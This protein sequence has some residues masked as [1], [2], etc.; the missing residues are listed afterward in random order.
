MPLLPAYLRC[1]YLTDPLGLEVAQPRLSWELAAGRRG[2]GQ[3][4]Y[5][6]RAAATRERLQADQPDLWDT[7]R[8]A[9]PLTTQAVYAGR[10]LAARERAWWQVRVWD[11]AEAPGPWSAPAWWEMGLLT[12]AAWQAQ[13]I[14]APL[15]GGPQTG[16]PAPFLRRAFTLARPPRTAR[17]YVTALGLYEMRLN[18]Q[19]V[20]E[21]V[22]TPGWT[23]YRRRVNYQAYDVTALLNAGDN[24]LGAVLG[25]G[26]YCG[27]LGWHG[28]QFYGDRP[29]LLAQLELT[30]D[31]GRTTLVSD[32]SWRY[33]FGPLLANDLLMGESYDAR[34]EQPGWDQP[35]FAEAGWAPAAVFPDPGL[36]LSGAPGPAVRPMGERTPIAVRPVPG[37]EPTRWLFDF[38]QNL[39]GRTRLTVSG[40]RGLTLTLRFAEALTA[41][42]QLY[43]ANLRGARQ[44][45]HYTLRGEGVETYEPRFTFHGFRYVEVAG[46]PTPLT[47]EALTAIVLHSET[48]PTGEFECSDPLLNQLQQ[49]IQWGQRGNF[50]EV[51]TDCPQRDERLGWTGDAQV[52]VRTAAFNMDVAAFFTK[53]Q[54]DLAEAQTALGQIPPVAP[55]VAIGEDGGPAWADAVLICPWTIYQCYGDER[56][57]AEHYPVFVRYLDYLR[58]TSPGLI[59]AHPEGPARQ[60]Y[61]DWLALDGSGD[62]RG[63]TPRDLI[64]T[65]FFAH[66]ADLMRQIATVL[67]K[68][69]DA[70]AYAQLGADVRR[71]FQARFLTPAGL[72]VAQTQTAYVLALHFDLL[73][74]AHR[75]AAVAALTADIEKRGWHL[76][77]GFVGTPYLLPVL[78]RFDRLEVAYRLLRQTTW[79]SWLYPVTQG[80]TTIWERW[81]GWTAERG[82]QDPGMNSFNHYAYGSVGAWMYAVVAGLDLDPAQPGFA[83]V[84]IRPRP[85]G[86]L[87][88]ARAAY[89]TMHGRL[90]CAWRVAAGR[91]T[92][93]VTIPPAAT[94][95][96]HV[97]ARDVTVDDPTGVRPLGR[98]AEADVFAVGPGTY[99]FTG[100]V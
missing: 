64:G 100:A 75:P 52:F 38:G 23:D 85:G 29:R 66:A 95:T 55:E 33:A 20:G 99:V 72:L 5:Q 26:W 40:P 34:L 69:A 53:W 94:A 61:G 76:S 81:D 27:Y 50:L 86:G 31:A 37:R 54:K 59:R 36:T 22:L 62:L 45:D 73:P 60:G 42:G 88:W 2:Q 8:V 39:V 14:G 3:T 51:P 17:L 28:R 90:A 74:E 47:A 12:R 68:P 80:A 43:T 10:P 24:V 9:A 63:Q 82:F 79:P 71:A 83:R 67:K 65:A 19:R 13:W 87:T 84:V 57:L 89:R 98:L 35:G 48:P 93:E 1:E 92:L 78:S 56:L 21:A 18:G 70:E 41:E 97:P 32:D 25:D 58:A 4:A 46:A 44:T 30:D 96:V 49:N 7:G 91:V 6:V 77:T 16:I 15:V 11:G